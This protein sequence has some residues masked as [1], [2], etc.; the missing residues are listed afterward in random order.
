MDATTPTTDTTTDPAEA[1]FDI[2]ARQ[3]KTEADVALLR[4]DVDEVKARVERI[5]RAAARPALAAADETAPEVKGFVQGYLRRGSTAEFKSITGTVPADGG[6]AVPRQIDA[7]IARALTDISPIRA[8]A[9]VVQTGSA[10]Y[11]KLVT[12]GSTAS[13]W[14]AETAGRPETGTPN[15]A[16]IAPPT[17]ELFANPAASQAMLDDAGFD[18][19]N[20]LAAE[21]ATEFARAEGAAFVNGTGVNQPKGFLAAPMSEDFDGDRPFGTLQYI[22]SG[23]AGGFDANPD[24]KLI[25]LVHTLKAGHRQGASFVMNSATLAEVRKL[26]TADGAF[27]WQPG[28]VDGQPDR[29]LGYP[30]VEAEDMPD[31]AADACP[32]AFGNFRHG[33]LIAERSATQVLRD[34]FTNKPFVHFYATKRVGG[35]VLDSNAIKLLK[36][37][38]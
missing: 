29:L 16:E 34:P 20:W 3:D 4:S 33:Y 28:L 22:A 7:A 15:F 30:V 17:G 31:I 10:G 11:R 1:S 19:E 32:I 26:K 12:T 23:D 38:L 8:I 35:Q 37:E 27:L 36:V 25:D 21:I 14:V 24:A 2:V 9:Q 5:G 13:G 18:I 6:Y